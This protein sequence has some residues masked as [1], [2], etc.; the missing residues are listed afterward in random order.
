MD[1]SHSPP[2][3]RR[4]GIAFGLATHALFG[5]TVWHLFFF[6]SGRHV[7]APAGPLWG[8]AILAFQ[9]ALP[10]SV[11]LHPRGREF[12]GRWIPQ[13]LYG[14]VFTLVTCL[15]LLVLFAGWRS[16]PFVFWQLEGW[17]RRLMYFGF[18][19]SW[20]GLFYSMS[21]TGLGY[22]TGW[23]PWWHWVHRRP[24]P[25][26]AFHPRSVYQWIRH[27]IYLS[28]LGLLW[29]TPT[30]TADRALLT[31]VWTIYI[32]IGS[33]LKDERLAYYLGDSYREYRNRV[34]AYP[35]F[36][37]ITSEIA[38]RPTLPMGQNLSQTDQP[39]TSAE[40]RNAA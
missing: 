35:F 25:K 31:G 21:L 19:F 18:G 16:H 22:Q 37:R 20:F 8:N 10:H 9:F 36:P 30:M 15:S 32:F 3:E 11:L 12:F 23:T 40:R 29:F 26:R 1:E 28:F 17:P 33:Y 6:L 5:V 39:R 2:R 34:R 27:P 4:V 13:P 24:L 7:N 14:C 38:L